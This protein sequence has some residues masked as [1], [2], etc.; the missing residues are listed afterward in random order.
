MDF[1]INLMFLIVPFFL[2]EQKV[3]TKTLISW[4]REEHLR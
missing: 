4:E 1:Q 3:M 2:Q